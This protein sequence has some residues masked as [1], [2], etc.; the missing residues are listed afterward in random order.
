MKMLKGIVGV[1]LNSTIHDC[2]FCL[3]NYPIPHIRNWM[4]Q[5]PKTI[6]KQT[7]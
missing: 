4:L 1:L 2:C 7:I 3:I 5:K 6:N